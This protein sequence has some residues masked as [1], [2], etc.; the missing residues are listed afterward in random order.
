MFKFPEL[1]DQF[2]FVIFWDGAL[3]RPAL[4]VEP[5]VAVPVANRALPTLDFGPALKREPVHHP[6]IVKGFGV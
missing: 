3:G 6:H 4:A 1:L 2:G 5:A